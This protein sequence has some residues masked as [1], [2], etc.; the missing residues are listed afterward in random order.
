[1]V[2]GS[3]DIASILQDKEGW[4]YFASGVSNS[5][6]TRQSEFERE[7]NLLYRQPADQHI[8]YFSSLAVFSRTSPYFK[9]KRYME[10]LVKQLP[11]YTIVRIGNIL[12]GTNPHT[13]LNAFRANPNLPIK[14]EYRYVVDKNEFLY[15]VNLAPE[16]N[17]E[18]NIPGKR[19]LIK[20][21]INEYIYLGLPVK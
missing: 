1:M 18:L 11:H 3:G 20:D 10:E 12:W 17:C 4:I 21:I 15:W 14:N 9:H 19:M 8:V 5:A 6:E 13:F 7:I 16:W 2:I